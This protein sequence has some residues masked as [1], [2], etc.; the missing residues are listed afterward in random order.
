MEKAIINLAINLYPYVLQHTP[1]QH[2]LHNPK[3]YK[4]T[5]RNKSDSLFSNR[6]VSSY[7]YIFYGFLEFQ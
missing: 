4:H 2:Y 7:Q 3:N 1:F 5:A 6:P